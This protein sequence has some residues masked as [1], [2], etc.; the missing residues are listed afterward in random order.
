MLEQATQ[1]DEF[2]L[3]KLR[4]D[5]LSLMYVHIDEDEVLDGNLQ[6]SAV[7]LRTIR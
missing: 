5:K 4:S 3:V 6:V 2:I 1:E 7:A